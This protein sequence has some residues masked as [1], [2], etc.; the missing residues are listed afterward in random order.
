MAKTGN[1][2][3][4]LKNKDNNSNPAVVAVNKEILADS[5]GLADSREEAITLI[6]LSPCLEGEPQEEEDEL[7]QPK[8]ATTM[9][10]CIWI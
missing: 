3:R 8:V 4:N 9:P 5:V 1:I 10:N 2:P 7:L 6:F